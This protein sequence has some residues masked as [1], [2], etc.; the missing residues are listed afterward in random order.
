MP[1]YYNEINK[2]CVQ[3]LRNLISA[4]HIA[5]GDVD[6]RS[7][8]EVTPDDLKGYTQCH[9]F[10]GIG[11]WPIAL[12]IAGWP[13]ERPVWTGSC[14]C[15]PYSIVGERKAFKDVRD[16]WPVWFSLMGE[17]VPVIFGEQVADA[18][19]LGWYD[20]LAD[21]LGTIKKSCWPIVLPA[22]STGQGNKGERLFIVAAPDSPGLEG[23]AWNEREIIQRAL[24]CGYVAT[25][26]ICDFIEGWDGLKRPIKPSIPLLA[27]GIPPFLTQLWAEGIGNAINPQVAAEIILTYMECIT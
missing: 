3:I 14:P 10:G 2:D 4:G 17:E 26:G 13:D 19:A 21:D 1:A 5:P 15:G 22:C 9:F 18:I 6:E 11:G 23:H 24:S 20:R 7:I 25:A 12:R 27:D 8:V 16:L